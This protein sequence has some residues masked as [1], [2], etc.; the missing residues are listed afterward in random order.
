MV[1][2]SLFSHLRPRNKSPKQILFNHGSH[3]S[4][5]VS[6]VQLKPLEIAKMPNLY[7]TQ[8]VP[9]KGQGLCA[10]REIKAGV[11]ILTEEVLFSIVDNTVDES[12]G[13]RITESFG[14][15]SPS[16]KQEFETLHCPDDRASNLWSPVVRRYLAN[17]FEMAVGTSGVFLKASRINHSCCPNACFAWNRYLGRLTVHAMT[18]IRAGEDI[19]VSYELPF[20]PLE[21]RQARFREFYGFTCDCSACRVAS[22]GNQTGE[23]RRQRMN[24]LFSTIKKYESKPSSHAKERLEMV[25]ELI[26]LAKDERLDGEF[27]SSMYQRASMLYEKSGNVKMALR[28]AVLELEGRT[29]L[30]GVDHRKTMESANA[31]VYLRSMVEMNHQ[32]GVQ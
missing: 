29:R 20:V 21:T 6:L 19:T 32:R 2:I 17:A 27:L 31:L 3:D 16:Q 14:S 8:S 1:D 13:N 5:F 26:K 24:V 22:Q 30:L 28:Y 23:M 25:V 11:R 10:D 18:D 12:I 9:G 4:Y 15:L 7:V